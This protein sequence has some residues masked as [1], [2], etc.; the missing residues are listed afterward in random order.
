[1]AAHEL[2]ESWAFR[3]T[4]AVAGPIRKFLTSVVKKRILEEEKR[5]VTGANKT[6]R[7]Q[8]GHL[9][10]QIKGN[11]NLEERE[12]KR[13]EQELAE[14]DFAHFS[15]FTAEKQAIA[16]LD[17]AYEAL[18]KN[19]EALIVE[20]M[21]YARLSIGIGRPADGNNVAFVLGEFD[22]EQ[23][24]QQFFEQVTEA[25]MKAINRPE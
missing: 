10:R 23:Y 9:M 19:V 3:N 14:F 16:E 8:R 20:K 18:T 2:K 22:P 17:A 11:K 12:K 21:S 5:E 6:L 13:L 24:N 4:E 1:Q 15:R 7:Q 25:L